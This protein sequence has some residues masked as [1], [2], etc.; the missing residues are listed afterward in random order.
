MI[1][2]C[3]V[4][5][6]ATFLFAVGITIPGPSPVTKSQ[7]YYYKL[8]CHFFGNSSF[9]MHFEFNVPTT[10]FGIRVNFNMTASGSQREEEEIIFKIDSG[11]GI[12]SFISPVFLDFVF[13][14]CTVS[15]R[16]V[17]PL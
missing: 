7:Y 2:A 11:R 15:S 1:D 13:V 5:S 4:N 10:C 8:L 3:R 14:G 6:R 12:S 17:P 9:T 16:S